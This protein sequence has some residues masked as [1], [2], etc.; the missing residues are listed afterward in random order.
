LKICSNCSVVS[1]AS[2]IRY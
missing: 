2:V 1:V